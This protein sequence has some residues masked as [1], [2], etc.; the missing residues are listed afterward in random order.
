M[1]RQKVHASTQ[2]EIDRHEP[3]LSSAAEVEM[4][5]FSSFFSARIPTFY[6]TTR[7]PFVLALP[8]TLTLISFLKRYYSGLM[9]GMGNVSQECRSVWR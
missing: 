9:V 8:V 7:A 5:S 3:V 4:N 6:R 2:P 1:N